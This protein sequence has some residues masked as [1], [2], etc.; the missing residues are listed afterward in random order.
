MNKL[1]KSICKWKQVTN[2][3]QDGAD[4]KVGLLYCFKMTKI[5]NWMKI[6]QKQNE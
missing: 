3:V 2:L 1:V 6:V 5:R 4:R